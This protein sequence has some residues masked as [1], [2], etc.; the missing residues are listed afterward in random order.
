MLKISDLAFSYGEK[1]LYEKVNFVV[2]KNQK[3]GLVGQNGS[4]KS[5]LLSIITGKETFNPATMKNDGVIIAKATVL[6]LLF[7]AFVS[8][9]SA[10]CPDIRSPRMKAGSTACPC[11]RFAKYIKTS[12]RKNIYFEKS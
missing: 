10:K 8:D 11:P 3:V 2:G 12:N 6:N 9:V 7:T 1:P 4:G 5:T